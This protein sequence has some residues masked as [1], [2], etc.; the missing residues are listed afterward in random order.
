MNNI[1][2]LTSRDPHFASIYYGFT[3]E[4]IE[5]L[6][7]KSGIALKFLDEMTRWYNGYLFW[8]AKIYNPW[9]I[10][11]CISSLVKNKGNAILEE[12]SFQ[13]YWG[14]TGSLEICI[15]LFR[16]VDIQHE[17]KQLINN[18]KL[19]YPDIQISKQYY[20]EIIELSRNKSVNFESSAGLALSNMFLQLLFHSGYLTLTSKGE[21][22]IP[23]KEI[24]EEFSLRLRSFFEATFKID[25]R[26]SAKCLA[27]LF[28]PRNQKVEKCQEILAEFCERFDEILELCPPFLDI[29][30]KNSEFGIHPNEDIQIIDRK[31]IQGLPDYLDINKRILIGLNITKEKKSE[32]ALQLDLLE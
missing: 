15:N 31:Y 24:R 7:K 9:A 18:E 19:D 26:Q 11:N 1:I 16:A 22:K 21:I 29:K 28:E 12:G 23:N 27:K 3:P 14:Q 10:I 5:I 8:K 2:K 30:E 13:N 32:F 6:L 17:I 4:E 25:F 20:Q